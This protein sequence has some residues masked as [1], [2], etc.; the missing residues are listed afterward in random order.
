MSYVPLKELKMSVDGIKA[1]TDKMKFDAQDYIKISER[2]KVEVFDEVV[3]ENEILNIP[4]GIETGV[5]NLTVKG[6]M[7]VKG[8][9]DVFGDI[10]IQGTLDIVGSG[11]VNLGV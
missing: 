11:E 4:S 2:P 6:R 1:Q 7:R 8:S 9:I 10:D 5:N 3:D